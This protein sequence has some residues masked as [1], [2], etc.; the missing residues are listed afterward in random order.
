MNT[1]KITMIMDTF[2]KQVDTIDVRTGMMESTMA[3]AT[4]ILTPDDEIMALMGQ[5]ADEHGLDLAAQLDAAG[6]VGVGGTIKEKVKD[7][8][9]DLLTERLSKLRAGALS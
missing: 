6:K 4:S 5:V 1:E 9:E 3:G 8:E 2:E 7:S